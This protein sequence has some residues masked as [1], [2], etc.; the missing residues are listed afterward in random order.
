M[1]C[2][3]L[4][5]ALRCLY[6][7]LSPHQCGSINKNGRGLVFHSSPVCVVYVTVGMCV[8]LYVYVRV[9]VCWC[10]CVFLLCGCWCWVGVGVCGIC[11]C[12]CVCVCVCA[13]CSMYVCVWLV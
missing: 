7:V 2:C 13:L 8:W 12:V 11:V 10:V 4:P 6:A 5:E 9:C 3:H 1:Q